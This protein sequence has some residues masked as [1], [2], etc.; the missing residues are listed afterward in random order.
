MSAAAAAPDSAPLLDSAPVVEPEP[1]AAAVEPPPPGTAAAAQAD[2]DDRPWPVGLRLDD[3]LFIVAGG[4]AGAVLF[5]RLGWVLLYLDWYRAHTNAVLDTAV[6][7]LTLAGG[8]VGGILAGLLM[9]VVLG[10]PVS[11]WL[12]VAIV[13]LLAALAG[14]KLA[15]LLGGGGR[16]SRTTGSGRP[17]SPAPGPG[18]RS[19]R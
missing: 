13:P 10:T 1:P 3:L 11:R 16:G 8:V 19:P 18:S 12:G 17:R 2:L 14:G 7:G 5:G 9:A 6:G 4:A 15:M